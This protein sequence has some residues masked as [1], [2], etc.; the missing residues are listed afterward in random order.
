MSHEGKT[1]I[2]MVFT[3][4]GEQIA[5]GDRLFTSHAAWMKG[6]HHQEGDKA[7]VRYN[8][9]RGPE[10][11]NSLDPSSEPTGRT[12]FALTEV[13]ETPEGVSDHWQQAPTWP[14]FE[15]FVGWSGKVDLTVLHGTPI[16][17]SLW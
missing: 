11:S 2:T 13:Y 10:L 17:Y 8:V 1:Q 15:A 6:T 12:T 4:E 7:L 14:D 5:E 16:A 3:A 9:A